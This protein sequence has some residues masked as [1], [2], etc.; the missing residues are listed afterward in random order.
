MKYIFQAGDEFCKL[1]IDRVNKK[2]ELAT[3]RT[4]YRFIPQAYWKLFGTASRTLVGLKPPTEE[5][6]RKE[7]AGMETATDEEFEKKLIKDFLDVGYIL[8][9]KCH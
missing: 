9:L 4:T 3:G 5:E 1:K 7:M 8:K 2:F 6:S